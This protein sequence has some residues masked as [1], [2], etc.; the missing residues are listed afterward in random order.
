MKSKLILLFGFV[1]TI[2]LPIFPAHAAAGAPAPASKVII[3]E[4]KLGGD[5]FSQGA[6]QPKD[7][8]EFITLYNQSNTDVDLSGWV[9][10]YAK[11]TLTALTPIGLP[12]V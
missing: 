3:S 8:Q 1:L 2:V 9:L 5:S 6:D 12:T 4:V 11:T 10:E 7:P